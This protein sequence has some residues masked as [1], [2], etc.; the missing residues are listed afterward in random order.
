MAASVVDAGMQA[1]KEDLAKLI[2]RD[3]VAGA[4]EI[5]ENSD[6]VIILNQ[7]VKTT[8]GE[9]YMTF[10]L[11]KRRYRSS[12]DN[13]NMRRLTYFNQPY[14]VGNE[15]KLVDD[16]GLSKPLMVQSLSSEMSSL[17]ETKRGKRNVVEREE[18][19]IQRDQMIQT[20]EFDPFDDSISVQF[21]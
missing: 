2:G 15:I 9:L 10:K 19:S 11:L 20:L 1:K 16:V 7:E 5:M 8:T 18:R 17:E 6:V 12:D 13:E 4:W 3:G 21:E 14:E